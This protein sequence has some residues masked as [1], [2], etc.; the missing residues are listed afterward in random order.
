V[1]AKDPASLLLILLA[2]TYWRMVITGLNFLGVPM[3]TNAIRATQR[4]P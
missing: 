2:E 3:V 1:L 4:Y